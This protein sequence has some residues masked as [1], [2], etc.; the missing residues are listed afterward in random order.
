MGRYSS[1]HD[2][3]GTASGELGQEYGLVRAIIR[4][5][6]LRRGVCVAIAYTVIT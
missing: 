2:A 6:L 5:A 1:G 3:Q 4:E